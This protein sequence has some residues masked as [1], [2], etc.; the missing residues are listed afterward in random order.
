M[1][2]VGKITYS[3]GP[4]FLSSFHIIIFQKSHNLGPNTC[5]HILCPHIRSPP[6]QLPGALSPTTG[7][8]SKTC[9]ALNT[10]HRL[11]LFFTM[12]VEFRE[13]TPKYFCTSSSEN[14]LT[15]SDSDFPNSNR[16]CE[17]IEATENKSC[18]PEEA[19]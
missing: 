15:S 19:K 4:T 11:A 18:S 7:V 14:V 9:T 8:R 17:M 6:Q 12:E 5:P 2:I 13:H 1:D 3:L 10:S 16:T